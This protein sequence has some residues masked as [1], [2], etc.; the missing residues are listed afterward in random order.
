V[1][2]FDVIPGDGPSTDDIVQMISTKVTARTF[3]VPD[4]YQVNLFTNC[5]GSSDRPALPAVYPWTDYGPCPYQRCMNGG[6]CNVK[7]AGE[8]Y[9]QC[10]PPLSGKYCD[11]TG[12][13]PNNNLL[14]LLT[15]PAA[16]AL[17]SLILC[18]LCCWS[19]QCCC[20]GGTGR[21]KVVEVID[22]DVYQDVDARSI[23]SIHS[24]PS[25]YAAPMMT[26]DPGSTYYGAVGRPFAVAFNDNTFSAVGYASND[27]GL[28]TTTG[29]KRVPS[30]CG[31]E[32]IQVIMNGRRG[33]CCGSDYG[34]YHSAGMG[35]KYAVA[36]NDRTFNSYSSMPRYDRV[37]S[38]N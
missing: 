5:Y 19:R 30:L 22:D 36:Y 2:Q 17:L 12:E 9:C 11:G 7:I 38:F 26:N 29:I 20:F 16:I 27:M 25:L 6:R 35:N 34:G 31:D 1:L 18:C 28:Y 4:M 3:S 23:R 21:V 14:W 37:R 10:P 33:S 8:Y 15:I 32:E 24:C 13:G